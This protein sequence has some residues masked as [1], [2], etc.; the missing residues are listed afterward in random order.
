MLEAVRQSFARQDEA[1]NFMDIPG[2][3]H[4]RI[5]RRMMQLGII[6]N[7]LRVPITCIVMM[8]CM[9]EPSLAAQSSPI[10]NGRASNFSNMIRAG[11][12]LFAIL[13]FCGGA[14]FTG[15]M[16]INI[17]RK[18]EWANQLFGA[19]GCFGFGTVVAVLYSVSQGRPVDVGT[20]F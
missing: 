7:M 9:A 18:N 12:L 20:D 19:L 14:V 1:F 4:I 11:L 8:L 17:G 16:I 10:F 6:V 13:L 15:L 2:L 3:E 5:G